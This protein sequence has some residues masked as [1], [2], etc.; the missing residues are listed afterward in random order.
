M[1]DDDTATP[2]RHATASSSYSTPQSIFKMASSHILE[3]DNSDLAVTNTNIAKK[4]TI[5]K[6]HH[7]GHD[8]DASE[9]PST[10]SRFQVI[11]SDQELVKLLEGLTHHRIQ[12]QMQ[13]LDRLSCA[14]ACLNSITESKQ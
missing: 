2:G 6:K 13:T 11:A 9:K 3:E 5:G 7:L 12:L 10:E 14:A 4:Y 8:H 1:P